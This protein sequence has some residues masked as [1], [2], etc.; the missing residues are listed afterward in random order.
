MAQFTVLPTGDIDVV[1]VASIKADTLNPVKQYVN[2]NRTD[3]DVL[4][5][6]K[7]VYRVPNIAF[8]QNGEV[9]DHVSLR[10]F[11]PTD[12]AALKPYKLVN[13]VFRP[14]VRD[15]QIAWSITADGLAEVK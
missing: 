10:V 8:R 4:I 13:P 12:I 2:G 7:K 3:D 5:D 11:N 6:G 1:S 15:N 14:Y 9:I